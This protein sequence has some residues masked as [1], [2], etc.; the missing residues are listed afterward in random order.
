MKRMINTSSRRQILRTDINA[1]MDSNA[2]KTRWSSRKL[3]RNISSQEWK[4]C[5]QVQIME[6]MNR[7]EMPEP[8]QTEPNLTPI[9]FGPSRSCLQMRASQM[10]KSK[11]LL[12]YLAIRLSTIN[13]ILSL[14]QQFVSG[15]LRK[16]NARI[17]TPI[18]PPSYIE[19][20]K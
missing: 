1:F 7:F 4:Y 2:S 9:R 6:T 17:P 13:I 8:G 11:Q 19:R 18:I 16:I 14:Q 3:L 20:L 12:A 5:S 10:T 15:Y